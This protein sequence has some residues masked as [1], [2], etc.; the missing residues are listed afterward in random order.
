MGANK[1]DVIDKKVTKSNDKRAIT[2]ASKSLKSHYGR[3]DSRHHKHEGMFDLPCCPLHGK[4][5]LHH[6]IC[7]WH[8]I[9]NQCGDCKAMFIK[10]NTGK[11]Q[12]TSLTSQTS[13]SDEESSDLSQETNQSC[14]NVQETVQK[15]ND[16]LKDMGKSG[17]QR[18]C[19]LCAQD[20][21]K[22]KQRSES[23]QTQEMCTDCGALQVVAG[24]EADNERQL[25]NADNIQSGQDRT[26][27]VDTSSEKGEYKTALETS[28]ENFNDAKIYSNG[29]S[30]SVHTRSHGKKQYHQKSYERK[31]RK[32]QS[33]ER[34]RVC[35]VWVMYIRIIARR[36]SRLYF[37]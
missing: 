37:F 2:L 3:S 19:S 11:L 24:D 8:M 1:N 25:T 32:K 31:P 7:C 9:N 5:Q 23:T 28:E 18:P 21:E 29:V 34:R 35:F 30:P 36:K 14:E 16:Q 22:P 13:E 27:L 26:K 15:P 4:Y 20:L 33:F 17:K 6:P 10:M 12:E